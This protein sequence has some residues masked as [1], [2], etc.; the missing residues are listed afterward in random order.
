METIAL[1]VI[2]AMATPGLGY[3]AFIGG[4]LLATLIEGGIEMGKP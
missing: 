2:L 4:I 3:S 1:I